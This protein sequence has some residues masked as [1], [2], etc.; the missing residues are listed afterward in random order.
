MGSLILRG[1]ED[2]VVERLKART[3]RKARSVEAE[4]RQIL[5]DA[6]ATEF[7]ALAAAMRALTAGRRHT[8]AEDLLCE[9]R[10]ER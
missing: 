6:L 4:H 9:A 8:P 10:E 1:L 2:E 3:A 7:N 5:C